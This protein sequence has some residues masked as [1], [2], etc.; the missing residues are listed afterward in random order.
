MGG[1]C[2]NSLFE[3]LNQRAVSALYRMSVFEKL[4][5]RDEAK[6][7]LHNVNADI[8]DRE[9]Q[10]NGVFTIVLHKRVRYLNAC[11]MS[12]TCQQGKGKQRHKHWNIVCQTFYSESDWST[13]GLQW[14][15]DRKINYEYTKTHCQWS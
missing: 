14:S 6:E 12:L 7:Q 2:K 1:R 13:I 9:Q 15:T 5:K 3:P 4:G 10:N 8:E 11:T